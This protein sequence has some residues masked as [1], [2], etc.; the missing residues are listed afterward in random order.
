MIKSAELSHK[1]SCLNKAASDEPIF[2]LRAKDPVAAETVRQWIRLASGTH[3]LY[4]LHEAES[5]AQAMEQYRARLVTAAPADPDLPSGAAPPE[6][7]PG[8]RT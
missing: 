8:D 2:V 3:E 1:N 7:A 4:K 6:A 5:L